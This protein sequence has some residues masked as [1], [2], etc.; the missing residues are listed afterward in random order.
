MKDMVFYEG[1]MKDFESPSCPQHNDYEGMKD[2]YYY[3]VLKKVLQTFHSFI[4]KQK[5]ILRGVTP[6]KS[7]SVLHNHYRDAMKDIVS[8]S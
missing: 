4:L 7:P 2:F 1:L 6:P 3:I 5:E 8:P